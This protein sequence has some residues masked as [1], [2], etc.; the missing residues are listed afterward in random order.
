M[1]KRDNHDE[2]IDFGEERINLENE[3]RIESLTYSISQLKT[4]ATYLHNQVENDGKNLDSMN[5]Q[6]DELMEFL[7]GTH[8]IFYI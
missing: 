1:A 7:N 4:S 3:Q 6:M 8:R 5:N 2:E